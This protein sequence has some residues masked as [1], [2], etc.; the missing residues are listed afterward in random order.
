MVKL[1]EVSSV[2]VRVATGCTC[3]EGCEEVG[4]VE[5]SSHKFATVRDGCGTV[6]DLVFIA[7]ILINTDS[8]S[9][10]RSK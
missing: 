9:A 2:R 5:P 10:L 7:R 8:R 4:G 1:S 3:H 6:I